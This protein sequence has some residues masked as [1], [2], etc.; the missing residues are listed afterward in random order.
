MKHVQH[1]LD[2]DDTLNS[3]HVCTDGWDRPAKRLWYERSQ[4]GNTRSSNETCTYLLW[5][6]H[7]LPNVVPLIMCIL[8]N[9][10]YLAMSNYI[11]SL[12]VGAF[13]GRIAELRIECSSLKRSLLQLNQL[14]SSF[15]KESSR[16]TV[17][18]SNKRF[19]LNISG[20]HVIIHSETY[21]CRINWS[22]DQSVNQ[23]VNFLK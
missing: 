10:F 23:P 4:A 18:P 1:E 2:T 12:W 19:S 8:A 9:L 15:L 14:F 5:S 22:T 3:K 11:L 13:E 16:S 6:D 20:Q 17:F 21:S 7:Q